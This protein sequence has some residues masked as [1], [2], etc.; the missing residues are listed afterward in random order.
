MLAIIGGSGL[1]RLSTL[2]V[3]RTESVATPY[4]DPSAPLVIGRIAGRDVVFLA[5][6]GTGHSIPPHRINYRAN[7]W[8]LKHCGARAV[9]AV[10]T[11]GGIREAA[12]GEL[13]LPHQVIDYTEGREVTYYDGTEGRPVVHVD[14]THPYT[15]SLR[16]AC[17]AAAKS[18]GVVVRDGGVHGITNGPRLETAAE[19]D[20]MERDGA[21][22]VG[23]TGMPEASLARELEL[24]FA[25]IALVVNAAA[26]RGSSTT[27][28][29]MRDIERVMEEGMERV[30]RVINELVLRVPE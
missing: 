13:L 11:V 19:I 27:A 30:R 3:V 5:R 23:M 6:H 29:S 9:V 26:G 2:E 10:A 18:A 22:I 14:F 24:P 17:M 15:E 4:G 1:T 20:R 21:T 16:A 7:L 12:T 28:I 25:V 8:A